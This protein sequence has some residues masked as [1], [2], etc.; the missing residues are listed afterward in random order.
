MNYNLNDAIKNSA[1]GKLGMG[2]FKRFIP[3]L[4]GEKRLMGLVLIAIAVNAGL[5]LLAPAIIGHVIDAYIKTG[6]YQGVILFSGILLAIYAV[7][8]V[9]SY[10]Q[11]RVMGGVGQRVLFKLRNVIFTKLLSLP[12]AFFNQNQTGDLISRINNDTDKLNQFF[13]QALIQFTRNVFVV[14]GAGVAVLVINVR[15]GS[16]AL[17]PA[18]FLFLITR[19]ITVWVKKNN[20]IN[21]SAGGGLSAEVQ[22]ALNNFK[23]IIA[24][25]RQDYFRDRFS[26]A[27]MKNYGAALRAGFSNN[28]FTP[29]YDLAGNVALLAVFAYGLY[30]I[31]QNKL[32][33][34]FLISYLIYVSRFYDPL[35]QM[36][37]IWATFQVALAAWDR[38]IAIL[39]MESN[40]P[41]IT[42][43]ASTGN[44]SVMEFKNVEFKY[45]DGK[46]V[47]HK[48]NFVLEAGKT[49]AFVGPT[50]GGK[51]T[52][53]SLMARLYDPT[54]GTVYLCGRD[55]RAFDAETL[56]KEVG[57]ILQEPFLF[58]GTVRE[59]L[60]YGHSLLAGKTS[61]QLLNVLK[62]ADLSKLLGRF[63]NG[64]ETPVSVSGESISLGQKQ[65]IAFMRA[66][67]R[68]PKLL[69][70]DEAT[71]NVDTVTEQL[72]D[73]IL[74]HLPKETTRVVIAHRLNTIENADEIF[75]VNGGE[76]TKAGSMEHAVEMLLKGK[77]AS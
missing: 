45:P 3:L 77:R 51:T 7:S 54:A 4:T 42:D 5:D 53:A 46:S 59:N 23:V 34:G 61:G 24:F 21:L 17:V 43:I 44:Q 15:L 60:I 6:K 71:A 16:V 66:V 48:I 74:S 9:A 35:R 1:T 32:T 13:A 38:I 10:V 65:L 63:P 36:A 19:F 49:Y 52:T 39:A 57:F 76:I 37:S 22:E 68:K 50:G 14:L 30:L 64:L 31:T 69:I 41:T 70:L 47:L 55:I 56:T 27:N 72:L 28:L 75:F 58:S 25:N 29:I 11:T 8:S 73:E 62:D 2:R 40:L 26:I 12:I 18:L 67:L 33:I 20:A